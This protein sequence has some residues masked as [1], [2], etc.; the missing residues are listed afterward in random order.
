MKSLTKGLLVIMVLLTSVLVQKAVACEFE[1]K[2]DGD[3]KE[4]YKAGDVVVVKVKVTFTHMVCDVGIQKTKFETDGLKIEGA[5][6]WKETSPGI[7]ERKLKLKVTGNDKGE[8]VLSGTRTC[9]KTGGY[10]SLK[11]NGEAK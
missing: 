9:N 10:G 5:T 4:V 8:L 1:F 6:D 3:K 7:W 2:V 11:L